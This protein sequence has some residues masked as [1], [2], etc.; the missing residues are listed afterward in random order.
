MTHRVERSRRAAALRRAA[1]IALLAS[2]LA[3]PARAAAAGEEARG[4]EMPPKKPPAARTEELV[5]QVQGVAVADPYRWLEDSGRDE[6]RRWVDEQNDYTHALLA[7][8]PAVGALKSRL[9]TLLSIGTLDAPEVRGG[10]YFY[11]RREGTQNQPILYVREERK[12][13]DRVLVD[14]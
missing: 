8:R 1:V 7:A 13:K 12:G 10:R 3:A 4:T 2:G 11:T 14:T 5:E 9:A 6:V